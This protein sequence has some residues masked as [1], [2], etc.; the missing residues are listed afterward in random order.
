MD[1]RVA[2]IR[3]DPPLATAVHF[4]AGRHA[5]MVTAS[6]LRSFTKVELSDDVLLRSVLIRL[7]SSVSQVR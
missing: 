7:P 6:Q 1:F 4:G 2:E 3:A 5:V